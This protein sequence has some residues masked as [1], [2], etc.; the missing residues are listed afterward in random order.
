ME[1]DDVELVRS[2]RDLL[3]HQQV[4]AASEIGAPADRRRALG[5]QRLEC[6]VGL[7]VAAG[8]QRHVVALADELI[9]KTPR[10][11]RFRRRVSAAHFRSAAQPVR[12]A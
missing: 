9:V 4:H 11:A 6:G 5:T 12:F 10:P 7:R 3:D 8:K 2:L 1:V